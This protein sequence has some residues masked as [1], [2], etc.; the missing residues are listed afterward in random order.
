MKVRGIELLD[1]NTS[2]DVPEVVDAIAELP[3]SDQLRAISLPGTSKVTFGRFMERFRRPLAVIGR[4]S[5]MPESLEQICRNP[6]LA[7]GLKRLN[8]LGYG[9]ADQDVAFLARCPHFGR[10]E[11]LNLSANAI[12]PEG[13]AFLAESSM[14]PNL[15]WL[16]L[17]RNPLGDDGWEILGRLPFKQLRHL[18]LW[19]CEASLPGGMSATSLARGRLLGARTSMA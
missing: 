4:Q 17:S 13:I 5:W 8:L 10:L 6:D 1:D 18:L 16:N 19:D 11:R 7:S 12:G 14:L 15:K 9:L 3:V 2:D